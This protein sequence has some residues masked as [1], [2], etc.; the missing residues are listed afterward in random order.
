M[1]PKVRRTAAFIVS[2]AARR[3]VARLGVG[4]HRSDRAERGVGFLAVCSSP[5]GSI[6]AFSP[7][8]STSDAVLAFV[9]TGLGRPLVRS[10]LAYLRRQTLAG[11]VT[12]VGLQAKVRHGGGRGR[13]EPAH[14]RRHEPRS[15]D[16]I[17]LGG[18]GHIGTAAVF[19]QALAS[20]RSSRPASG[21]PHG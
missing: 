11:D 17:Q 9:A 15:T 10:G 20:W 6:P 4:D 1:G 3:G 5:N 18:N 13:T 12:G 19:D 8:G 7:I 2:F 16:P 14:V 21:R